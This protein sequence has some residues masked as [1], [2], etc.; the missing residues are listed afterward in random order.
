MLC[1]VRIIQ[2]K[3]HLQQLTVNLIIFFTHNLLLNF[4]KIFILKIFL[5]KLFYLF[6]KTLILSLNESEME[7]YWPS[8]FAIIANYYFNAYQKRLVR[9]RIGSQLCD[10]IIFLT[11]FSWIK[12]FFSLENTFKRDV[13]ID[14]SKDSFDS[15]HQ[16]LHEKRLRKRNKFNAS[17]CK[18][19]QK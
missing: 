10:L 15:I 19:K 18:W 8:G 17:V 7:V 2:N 14:R 5:K 6:L 1:D 12:F 16:R 3:K 13:T 4:I 11:I 9:K